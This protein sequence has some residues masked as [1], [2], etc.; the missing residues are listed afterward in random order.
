M[1]HP[2]HFRRSRDRDCKFLLLSSLFCPRRKTPRARIRDLVRRSSPTF[3]AAPCLEE[4]TS[5]AY[6]TCSASTNDPSHP[7]SPPEQRLWQEASCPRPWCGSRAFSGRRRRRVGGASRT[8]VSQRQESQRPPLP[9]ER[10][11]GGQPT[12]YSAQKGTWNS[13]IIPGRVCFSGPYEATTLRWWIYKTLHTIS[14]ARS[15]WL[16]A[17]VYLGNRCRVL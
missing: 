14:M 7:R 12:V 1:S 2:R 3:A 8:D 17:K 9:R 6:R 11:A 4:S 13:Q 10:S 15:D 5:N 16:L